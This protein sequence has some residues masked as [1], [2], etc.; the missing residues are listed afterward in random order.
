MKVH[1]INWEEIK[2]KR[3]YFKIDEINDINLPKIIK[4]ITVDLIVNSIMVVICGAT[5]DRAN[6]I[7]QTPHITENSNLSQFGKTI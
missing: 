1:V 3:S 5:N 4:T 6:C 2:L 7:K